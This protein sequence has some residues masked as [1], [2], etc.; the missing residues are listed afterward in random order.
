MLAYFHKCGE[1]D[2]ITHMF[3]PIDYLGYN[4]GTTGH[5]YKTRDEAEDTFG[6]FLRTLERHRAE[7]PFTPGY[8]T[9]YPFQ[10]VDEEIA[11]IRENIVLVGFT[12]V[13]IPHPTE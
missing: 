11:W 7:R 12:P 2:E 6:L 10:N 9:E 13:V 5:N 1:C 3:S 8:W 4:F